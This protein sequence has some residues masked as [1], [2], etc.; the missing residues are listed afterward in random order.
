M[1][2]EGRKGAK[3]SKTGDR[4]AEMGKKHQRLNTV[5]K[6]QSDETKFTEK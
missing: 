3:D 2:L 5:L 1:N 4:K 6:N